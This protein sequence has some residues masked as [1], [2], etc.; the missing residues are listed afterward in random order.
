L[1]NRS[2]C[3]LVL[4]SEEQGQAVRKIGP[5]LEGKEHPKNQTELS[6]DLTRQELIIAG[7]RT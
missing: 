5:E 1:T 3:N 7:K 2:K 6:K 4:R